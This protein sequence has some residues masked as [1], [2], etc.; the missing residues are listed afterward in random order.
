MKPSKVFYAMLIAACAACFGAGYSLKKVTTVFVDVPKTE[1]DT[2][3][4]EVERV[5]LER[6]PAVHDTVWQDLVIA[7][8]DTLYSPLDMASTD[9]VL[10]SDGVPYGRLDVSYY[11]PPA[12]WFDVRFDPAPLPTIQVTKYIETGRHWYNNPYFT[13]G[14]GVLAGVAVT[15]ITK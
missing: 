8:H 15:Q 2:L 7:V 4:V 1:T 14:A 13:L 9:V 10:E 6:L 12:D 3:Y 11:L 5:V